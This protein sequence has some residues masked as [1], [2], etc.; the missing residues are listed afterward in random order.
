MCY[1]GMPRKVSRRAGVPRKVRRHPGYAKLLLHRNENMAHQTRIATFLRFF[2]KRKE[3]TD[4]KL[5]GKTDFG[6]GK[7]KEDLI[8]ACDFRAQNFFAPHPTILSQLT[9]ERTHL[10]ISAAR[11][12]FRVFHNLRQERRQLFISSSIYRSSRRSSSESRARSKSFCIHANMAR[13][14]YVY[15]LIHVMRRNTYS[16]LSSFFR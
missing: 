5:L 1:V 10:K 4:G 7:K 6:K 11:R 15:R 2:R 8:P 3:D 9:E 12:S 16:F 13:T 14:A